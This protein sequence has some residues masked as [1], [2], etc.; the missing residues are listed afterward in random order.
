MGRATFHLEIPAG[1]AVDMDFK[2]GDGLVTLNMSGLS[3]ERLNVD[4]A[5]GDA[6]IT[7]PAYQPLSTSTDF[8]VGTLVVRGAKAVYAIKP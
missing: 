6:F 4:V 5:K 3:L 8:L 2:G 7:V 1:V